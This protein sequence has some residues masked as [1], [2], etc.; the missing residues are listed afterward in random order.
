MNSPSSSLISRA[1]PAMCRNTGP[2]PVRQTQEDQVGPLGPS[3]QRLRERDI[4]AHVSCS[5]DQR[6]GRRVEGQEMPARFPDDRD[7]TEAGVPV[8]EA[9]HSGRLAHDPSHRLTPEL[10]PGGIPQPR[11]GSL[12]VG[13]PVPFHHHRCLHRQREDRCITGDR[14]RQSVRQCA[15]RLPQRIV[16]TVQ[17]HVSS[18]CAG[19]AFSCTMPDIEIWRILKNS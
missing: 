8:H 19:P 14:P 3:A 1:P 18:P 15:A 17:I 13:D 9:L 5:R 10:T 6:L 2:E 11:H 4:D 7:L 16:R 12:A